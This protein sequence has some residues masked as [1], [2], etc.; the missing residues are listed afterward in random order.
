[1]QINIDD[2]GNVSDRFQENFFE[3]LKQKAI[4]NYD[5][6]IESLQTCIE[7]NPKPVILY[8]ELGKN[9][10]KLKQY[11]KAEDNFKKVVEAKPDDRYI[12]ELLFEVYFAER[13]YPESIEIVEKLVD[14]NTMFKEQLANLYFLE[15]RY[16]DA[17]NVL[18]ELTEERGRDAYRDQLRKR[19]TLKITNPTNQIARLEK[20][21]EE[22]PD[23]EQNY[24]NLIYLYSQ[25][26]Q[27]NK[28]FDTAKRLLKKQPKSELVHL[29]LYKFYL[30]DNKTDK[31]VESMKIALASNKLDNES[32]Y[33]VISDFLLF[34]KDNPQYEAQLEEITN[35]FSEGQN[36]SKVLTE[37]GHFYYKKDD[38]ELALN[39]YERG[40]KTNANDFGLL[41]RILLLQ[42]DL[43]RYEKAKI[44]SE[45]ALEM[46]PS[47]PIFYLVNGVSLVNLNQADQAVEILTTGIDYVIDDQK[48]EADFYKQMGEAYLKLGDETKA[49]EYFERSYQLQKKS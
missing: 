41:K 7:I 49:S 15:Q 36:N 11:K 42:L 44:G 13:K 25:D 43:K 28:A 4:T 31:A 45:L 27:K 22:K 10:L 40:I 37:L 2:L 16:D 47:Q 33:K 35:V 26:N 32:K 29:A 46:F 12:L 34:V 20:K 23:D 39:Y 14:Y 48:M 18:D 24:L 3:A 1:M 8:S 9:Y 38:K 21:I 19:I 6:A 5:K 30:D 17:L